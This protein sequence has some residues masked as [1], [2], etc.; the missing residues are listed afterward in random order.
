MPAG[1]FPG[2]TFKV[3]NA[4]YLRSLG[5]VIPSRRVKAS[6]RDFLDW[7]DIRNI[8]TVDNHLRYLMAKQLIVRHWELGST[9]GSEYEVFLP[10]E[11]LPPVTTTHHQSPPL[12]TTQ[13]M[14]SG[15]TQKLGSGGD[16]QTI[17]SQI[18]YGAPQTSYKTKDQSD[19]E[20]AAFDGLVEELKKVAGELT[21]KVPSAA[22]NERWRELAQVLT[23]ELRIAAARTTVSNVPAFLAEHLRRRLWKVDKR[24][25]SAEGRELPDSSSMTP[26]KAPQDCP[27]C[28]GA[29]WWYPEG[30]EKGV[31]K[32]R[33]ERLAGG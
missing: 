6:R 9:E 26:V 24:Q 28:K 15:N 13:N 27:D 16:S 17:D 33:H 11:V 32:C 21:G 22:D 19:D 2:S 3:Y 30:Q 23:A 10:E 29:G 18:S 31:A 5:A 7:T 8:K 1:L 25:A 4:L 12:T 14:T 20:P